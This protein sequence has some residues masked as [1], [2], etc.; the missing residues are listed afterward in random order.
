M[1]DRLRSRALISLGVVT[2][3][4]AL[5]T[6]PPIVVGASGRGDAGGQR[7]HVEFTRVGVGPAALGGPLTG[8]DGEELFSISGPTALAGDLV[9][10]GFGAL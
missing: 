5:I 10:T 8:P 7:Q 3:L 9:G 2:V 4:A 6:G 1:L